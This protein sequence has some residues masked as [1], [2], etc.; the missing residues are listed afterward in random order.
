MST[1]EFSVASR[2]R[3]YHVYQDEWEA[4]LGEVL[5]CQREPGN[6]H[7]PYAVATVSDGRTVGHVPRNISP[8]CS[9]F[10]R[11][12]GVITCSVTGSRRYSA[13]LEQGGL[14][15]PC[16]L[17]FSTSSFKEKE[18]AEKLVSTT[19]ESSTEK[20][21][22]KAMHTIE[23]RVY[24]TMDCIGPDATQKDLKGERCENRKMPLRLSAKSAAMLIVDNDK[25]D[26]PPPT[27]VRKLDF[28]EIIMG[29]MLSDIHINA[30]QTLLK[31]QFQK[32]NGF[33]STLYQSKNIKWADEQIANKVQIIHCRLRNHWIV[34]TTVDCLKGIVKVYDSSFGSLDQ[35]SK[36]IIQNLFAV[37][38][39]QLQ[40]KLLKSQRQVGSTDCGLFSIANATAIAFGVNPGKLRLQQDSMRA[41]LVNC[42]KRKEITP[43]P[44]V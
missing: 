24:D 11:R 6:R 12:R 26:E 17:K 16:L 29:E 35:D 18:K 28:E 40:I 30:A 1:F 2:V 36:S 43:F 25:D 33:Q 21:D 22:N 39:A 37:D 31:E 20:I 8:I 19:L 5:S 9:I 27:K 15:I 3:G 7:D 34:A 10:I 14:E 13:D 23:H 32:L 42:L 38:D 4:V 41:H 44:T